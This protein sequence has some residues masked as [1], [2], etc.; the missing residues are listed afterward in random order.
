M[1]ARERVARAINFQKPDRVP[2][3]IGGT[4]VTGIHIDLYCELSRYLGLDLLPPK[5]YEQWQMLARPDDSMM[6]WLHA[7]V[8]QLENVTETWGLR[9]DEWKIWQTTVGNE[10][11]V[12]KGLSPV[13]DERGYWNIIS[14]DGE[15]LAFMAPNSIYFDKNCPTEM[16]GDFTRMD[17]EEWKRSIPLYTEEDL[18][19]I[20]KRAKF[21]HEYTDYSV[22]GGFLKGGLGTNGIF[23]GH[24]ICDWLCILSMDRE[25]AFEILQATAERA[26]ENLALYF[27]A[28]GAYIDTILISGTDYGT[29]TGELFNPEIFKEL[30]MPNYKLINDF[31]H[32]KCNAKTMIHSCGSNANI[33]DYIIQA[34]F[35][36]F[37]PV[38]TNTT[39]MDPEN[40][41]DK[42]GGRIVFWGGGAETQSVLP[43]GTADEVKAQV[44]ERLEIFGADGGYVFAPVHNLQYGVPPENIEAMIDTVIEYGK[45]PLAV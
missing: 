5:L 35:D 29:Q 16:T 26:I 17:P 1:T 14:E 11:L 7:D 42:F 8:I 40:L 15:V 33:L 12:P 36:I 18:R 31:V 25:Y 43:F 13:K 19:I 27:N 21:F 41:M 30:H 4:K 10:M 9:N 39:N 23:A 45:Y 3:D 34:G 20:E 38:H 37:N 24:T 28:V 22:H 2:I 32:E 6:K 44:K